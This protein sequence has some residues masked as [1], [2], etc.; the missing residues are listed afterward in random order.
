MFSEKCFPTPK[1]VAAQWPVTAGRDA[2]SNNCQLGEGAG[3][4][5]SA[6]QSLELQTYMQK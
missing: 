3:V 2:S 1:Q 4:V 6:S 5:N